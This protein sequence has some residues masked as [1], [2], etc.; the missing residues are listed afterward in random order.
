MIKLFNINDYIIDTS[1]FENVLNGG[2]VKEFEDQFCK[3]VGA[4][5]GCGVNSATNA[6]FLSLLNR[7]VEVTVPSVIPYV[8]LNAIL[9]SGNSIRFKDDID[10]VGDSYVLH[11]FKDYKIIDSA[12][13]VERSQFKDEADPDD[14][15]IFSFYPTK[16][17]GGIDGGMIVSDDRNKIDMFQKS[18]LNGTGFSHNSWEREIYFPGWKSYLSSSQAFVAFEN[19]KKLDKKNKRLD[20]IR[21]IYNRA[22]GLKNTSRHL[23]RMISN[24]RP[25][26]IKKMKKRGITCGIHYPAMHLHEVY[27]KEGVSLPISEDHGYRTVSIPFHEK[28]TDDQIAYI[29]KCCKELI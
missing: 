26:F 8:V 17:V 21:E 13:K 28:L 4:K 12:Q 23:Y 29:I 20:E 16:P 11:Q 18:V 6:I 10:W 2:I 22:L 7:N 1:K 9:L 25:D 5:Y 3:Y 15:M 24:N 19:L 27:E 14:L